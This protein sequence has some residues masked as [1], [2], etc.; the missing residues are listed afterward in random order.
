[1][2]DQQHESVKRKFFWT[3]NMIQSI[4]D[5]LKGYKVVCEFNNID[6]DADKSVQYKHVRK[7]L[8]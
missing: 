6:F 3:D 7:E 4:I 5:I 1:M 8:L 2:A